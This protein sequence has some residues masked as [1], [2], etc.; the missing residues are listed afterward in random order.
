[1]G[2]FRGTQSSI[3]FFAVS[4]IRRGETHGA[5]SRADMS[6]NFALQNIIMAIKD[7]DYTCPKCKDT[8]NKGS[9]TPRYTKLADGREFGYIYH[10]VVDNHGR[11]RQHS[12][13]YAP[14]TQD[15]K[16]PFLVEELVRS[17]VETLKKLY[18]QLESS[19]HRLQA[20]SF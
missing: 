7:A 19:N 20:S 11:Y 6:K 15:R 9:F 14:P 2:E 17:N 1:M 13:V 8:I 4:S 12:K 10:V 5:P 18:G 16:S 3:T